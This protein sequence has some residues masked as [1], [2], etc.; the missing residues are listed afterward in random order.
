MY[1]STRL[2]GLRQCVAAVESHSLLGL[3]FVNFSD[4]KSVP[5]YSRLVKPDAYHRP[6]S[7]D[8][9]LPHVNNNFNYEL[10][11]RNL[12]AGNC[13]LLYNVLSMCGQV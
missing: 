2:L 11:Y 13:T 3:V 10:I 12:A 4:L 7:T 8:V 9:C 6:V 1:T 5:A